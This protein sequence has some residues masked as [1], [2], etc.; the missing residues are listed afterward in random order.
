MCGN[1]GLLCLAEYAAKA[2]QRGELLPE[3]LEKLLR[4]ML[5]IVEMR[6]AQ[7]GGL[8]FIHGGARDVWRRRVRV[9]KPKRGDLCQSLFGKLRRKLAEHTP[10]WRRG[11]SLC[12]RLPSGTLL[13]QGHSRFGTSSV[14][15]VLETHPHQ[16]TPCG[17]CSVW[18]WDVARG[19]NRRVCSCSLSITH[20]G[21]FDAWRPYRDTIDVG[22]LG[23]W[24]DRILG[25]R[26]CA[27]GDSAKMAGMM[28]LLLCQGQWFNAVR[29]AYHLHVACHAEQASDWTPLG[30]EAPCTVPD[31]AVLRLWSEVLDAEFAKWLV[32]ENGLLGPRRPL[33][34]ETGSLHLFLQAA[35]QNL[36]CG[37]SG[38]LLEQWVP[39]GKVLQ[40]VRAAVESFRDNDLLAATTTFLRRAEGTFGV[41]VTSTLW[42]G[43]V[44]VAAHGQ[45]M[46][47]GFCGNLQDRCPSLVVWSSERAALNTVVRSAGKQQIA[48]TARLDLDD[49]WGEVLQLSACGTND[50]E[51]QASE[52]VPE[53]SIGFPVSLADCAHSGNE[54]FRIRGLRFGAQ[55][56]P[57]E[58]WTPLLMTAESFRSRL[59]RLVAEQDPQDDTETVNEQGIGSSKDVVARDLMQIPSL[60]NDIDLCWCDSMSMNYK[61]AE[62]FAKLL[63]QR[64]RGRQA[65]CG[66]GLRQIDLLVFGVESSLWLVQQFC[67]DLARLF[68]T[69]NAVAMS[70]NV[71]LG[72]LQS[73]PGSVP[74][75]NWTY[76]PD[77]F[78]ISSRT[79]GVAV[80]HSGTTYPTVWAARFLRTRTQHVFAMS[81]SFDSLLAVSIGQSPAQPFTQRVFSTMAGVRPAEAATIATVAMHHTLSYLLLRC[82][83]VATGCQLPSLE[84]EGRSRIVDG[85]VSQDHQWDTAVRGEEPCGLCTASVAAVH[86]MHRLLLSLH[87]ASLASC[88][89]DHLGQ[90]GAPQS[91]SIHEELR[92]AG[93]KWS[94]HITEGYWATFLPGIYVLLTVSI[95]FIPVTRL[96]TYVLE[97]CTASDSVM[98]GVL[99]L[100]R[101]MDALVYTFLSIIVAMIH[102]KCTGRRVWA[103][104]TTRTLVVVESTVN[105]KL[106]RAYTS[107]LLALSWRFATMSVAGQNGT[108]HFV[109]EFT[110]LAQSDVLLAVGLPDGRLHTGASAQAC[111]L[112]SAQQAKFIKGKGRGVELCSLGHNP[113]VRSGLFT[114][115]LSLPMRRPLFASEQVLMREQFD[116]SNQ[117][118]GHHGLAPSAVLQRWG[119]L[120]SQQMDAYRLPRINITRQKIQ[121]LISPRQY[122]DFNQAA[123]MLE[124]LL[125]K[126][127]LMVHA[128]PV[129]MD[130]KKFL[131]HYI[132]QHPGRTRVY[133][134]SPEKNY[135]SPARWYEAQQVQ[136]QQHSMQPECLVNLAILS[137]ETCAPSPEAD[138]RKGLSQ[139]L[140]LRTQNASNKAGQVF[141]GGLAPLPGDLDEAQFK[142]DEF[143]GLLH[144]DDLQRWVRSVRFRWGQIRQMRSLLVHLAEE[145]QGPQHA[146]AVVLSGGITL[147]AIFTAW[148]RFVCTKA[149]PASGMVQAE[150]VELTP[151]APIEVAGRLRRRR[152][153]HSVGG[154]AQPTAQARPIGQHLVDAGLGEGQVLD[155]LRL[156][157]LF[158]ETRVGS[159]ERLIGWYVFFHAMVEPASR[160][161]FLRFELGKSQSRLRVA[162]TPAPVPVLDSPTEHA[163]VDAI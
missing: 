19:W 89:L 64:L 80:S 49:Q 160:L 117:T 22:V 114:S 101:I 139:R 130:I 116:S 3:S 71:V 23:H 28:E 35:V 142:V 98:E 95:G 15:A 38:R 16:W 78:H 154:V 17:S 100:L 68:P 148:R 14:P 30:R 6:G 5:S 99:W 40:F 92:R 90:T 63:L 21:D 135:R 107:K 108:D 131:G 94:H 159:A 18:E 25:V 86:D 65:E 110:H 137:E 74:A 145:Y 81:A 33:A 56:L 67:A 26:H 1:W 111:T 53:G 60:L 119:D 158:Y 138:F 61:S 58:A 120:L 143:L 39:A 83:A 51:L 12:N 36:K 96:G 4:Q 147:G 122:L 112:M 155:G 79:L 133:V 55:H 72:L 146:L 123:E 20:N 84:R 126:Q 50:L 27:T 102:R 127:R 24:L 149:A 46:S 125:D 140:G 118:P 121:Q 75:Y 105:Y 104:F 41:T 163:E 70:S 66:Q 29:L 141:S 43:T 87:W 128:E 109:H 47:L 134:H 76:G 8:T 136:E 91:G 62:H 42:P 2:R 13:V 32:V 151:P 152:S 93:R 54:T 88:G 156:T 77:S 73:G 82:A 144:G 85:V 31:A 34:E 161:P 162:S 132:S 37:E 129:P 45:P 59:V 48:V 115:A 97:A 157:E 44:V 57:E 7:A 52:R 103:R 10:W 11:F 113:S 69:V 153:A 106:L 150:D 124:V 9:L